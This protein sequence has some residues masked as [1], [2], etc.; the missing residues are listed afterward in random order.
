MDL[1][2]RLREGRLLIARFCESANNALEA[3]GA[4]AMVDELSR[5]VAEHRPVRF[6]V[7]PLTPFLSERF[8]SSAALGALADLLDR[9]GCTAILT[10]HN[11]V[12]HGYDARLGPIVQNAAAVVHL[13]REEGGV[14]CMHAVQTRWR[15][16]P[17]HDARFTCSHGMGLMPFDEEPTRTLELVM[18]P[19]KPRP[20]TRKSST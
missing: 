9:F 5:L 2:A 4:T 15:P 18:P 20:R 6:A 10:Y 8:A 7:D 16:A 3:A 17:E 14:H 19:R 13:S 12:S 1:E 11:D